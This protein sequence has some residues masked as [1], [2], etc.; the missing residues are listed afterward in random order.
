MEDSQLPIKEGCTLNV[1]LPEGGYKEAEILS[2]KRDA[3]NNN[4]SKYY[5]HFSGF[6]KRLDDWVEHDRLDLETLKQPPTKEGQVD[7]IVD[8]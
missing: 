4:L 8:F 5:V 6:N 1:R 7:D 2:I 3:S